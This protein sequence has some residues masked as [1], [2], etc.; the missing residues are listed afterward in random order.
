MKS[1]LRDTSVTS[2][3]CSDFD[4]VD[5]SFLRA[6][7]ICQVSN[8][9]EAVAYRPLGVDRI[10]VKESVN[11]KC[12]APK[13]ITEH[14]GDGIGLITNLICRKNCIYRMFHYLQDSFDDGSKEWGYDYYVTRCV[15]RMIN[16]P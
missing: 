3:R 8:A 10:D 15:Q 13:A 7:T 14:V 9:N 6:S 12:K 5:Q 1:H 4:E 11:R 16:D 2:S